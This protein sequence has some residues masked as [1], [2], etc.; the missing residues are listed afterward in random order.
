[1]NQK[2]ADTGGMSLSQLVTDL[3]LDGR[4]RSDK[5]L[6]STGQDLYVKNR[7]AVFTKLESRTEHRDNAVATVKQAL[8]QEYAL[9]QEQANTLM[10]NVFGGAP[11]QVTV[12]NAL[13]LHNVGQMAQ[14]FIQEGKTKDAAFGLATLAQSV[15]GLGVSRELA[16]GMVREL[17]LAAMLDDIRGG[18][19][20][21]L[22]NKLALLPNTQ[23]VVRAIEGLESFLIARAEKF[24]ATSSPVMTVAVHQEFFHKK[25]EALEQVVH[26]KLFNSNDA[27]LQDLANVPKDKLWKLLIDG[28]APDKHHYDMSKGYMASMLKGL[29][30][31]VSE[32]DRPLSLDFLVELHHCATLH[33]T[34]Q[35]RIEDG[36]GLVGFS[37]QSQGLKTEHNEWGVCRTYTDLGMQELKAIRDELEKVVP[38]YFSEGG[39]K[40]G[41]D[42]TTVQWRSGTTGPHLKGQV[43]KLVKHVI[44]NG[45]DAIAKATST[46]EKLGAIVDLCRGL[47]MIHPFKDANGRLMMFLVLNKLLADNGLRPTLLQNQGLMVGQSKT[48]LIALIKQGQVDVDQL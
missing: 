35:T 27:R 47:G 34:N 21:S 19:V 29:D 14:E 6:R 20:A 16:M 10:S 12:G 32:I 30:K 22:R 39:I 25:T 26:D 17:P 11:A 42:P 37:F 38:N 7:S 2:V 9:S 24:G 43:E 28:T 46:D 33:V 44:A 5:E 23:A 1:M 4:G 15:I 8:V 18:D 3:R 36:F 41:N 13:A 45:Q 31:I 48:D 40:Y